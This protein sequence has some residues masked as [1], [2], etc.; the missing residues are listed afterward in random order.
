M[1]RAL[2]LHF[3]GFYAL[4]S[5]MPSWALSADADL[6]SVW[7]ANFA[8]VDLIAIIALGRA[9]GILGSIAYCTLVVSLIWSASLAVEM[10]MLQDILQQ[11]DTS[12]QRYFDIILGLTL[13]AGVIQNQLNPNAKKA[14]ERA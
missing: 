7:Y 8:L 4:N 9:V 1:V 11:A 12:M 2:V 3:L 13:M 5:W 14:G 6:L 10:A